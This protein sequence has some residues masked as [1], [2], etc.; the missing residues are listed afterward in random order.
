MSRARVKSTMES[1]NEPLGKDTAL[2][3]MHAMDVPPGVSLIEGLAS[4][5]QEQCLP[6]EHW[7]NCVLFNASACAGLQLLSSWK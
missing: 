2:L 6:H 4:K 3:K 7:S 5:A 1:H